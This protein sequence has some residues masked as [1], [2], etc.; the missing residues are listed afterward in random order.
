MHLIPTML[1]PHPPRLSTTLRAKLAPRP[2]PTHFRLRNNVI[3]LRRSV[4]IRQR[5]AFLLS[6][7]RRRGTSICGI[8]NICHHL[9]G[10]TALHAVDD[11]GDPEGELQEDADDYAGETAVVLAVCGVADDVAVGVYYVA[12]SGICP[13]R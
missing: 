13:L 7:T 2:H 1:T 12:G 4:Y 10:A 6:I 9:S 11:Q 8:I 3:R 5:C